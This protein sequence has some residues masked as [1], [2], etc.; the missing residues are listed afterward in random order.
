MKSRGR[1]VQVVRGR[2]RAQRPEPKERPKSDPPPPRFV[3]TTFPAPG[4][5]EEAFREAKWGRT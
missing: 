5:V 3:V 4:E 2:V 1:Y